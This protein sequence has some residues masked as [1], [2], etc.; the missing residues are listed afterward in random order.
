MAIESLPLPHGGGMGGTLKQAAPPKR[1]LAPRVQLPPTVASPAP[2]LLAPAP[3]PAAERP[4][5]RSPSPPPAKPLP[6]PVKLATEDQNAII[7]MFNMETEDPRERE[8]NRSCSP[9]RTC[10]E[11]AAPNVQRRSRKGLGPTGDLGE[12]L[13]D[14][15]RLAGRQRSAPG[16]RQ[17]RRSS[18]REALRLV[19]DYASPE[20]GGN[21]EAAAEEGKPEPELTVQTERPVDFMSKASTFSDVEIEWVQ[22][23]FETQMLYPYGIDGPVLHHLEGVAPFAERHGDGLMSCKSAKLWIDRLHEIEYEEKQ[24]QDKEAHAAPRFNRQVFTWRQREHVLLSGSVPGGDGSFWG[25]AVMSW[26]RVEAYQ[27][28]RETPHNLITVPEVAQCWLLAHLAERHLPNPGAVFSK[29]KR[30]RGWHCAISNFEPLRKMYVLPEPPEEGEERDRTVSMALSVEKVHDNNTITFEEA[31]A[32]MK[33][34]CA[35]ETSG[36]G[37]IYCGLSGEDTDQSFGPDGEEYCK[38]QFLSSRPPFSRD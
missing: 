8:S 23:P 18:S 20:E 3:A 15:D 11:N 27:K 33:N 26:T 24:R 30:G 19:A 29:K 35:Y 6:A 16:G 5:A 7:A 31:M 10:D 38:L 22:A 36:G 1:P 4:R 17:P 32:S 37:W 25:E 13:A 34:V 14:F 28:C 2:V 12:A 21:W 9:R